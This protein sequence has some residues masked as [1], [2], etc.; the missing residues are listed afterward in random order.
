MEQNQDV[1]LNVLQ[2]ID[3]INEKLKALTEKVDS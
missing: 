2:V 3:Q 1:E